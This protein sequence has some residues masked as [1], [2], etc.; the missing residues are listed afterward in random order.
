MQDRN[1]N[2]REN[3]FTK[4]TRMHIGTASPKTSRRQIPQITILD[5]ANK[6]LKCSQ[7]EKTFTQDCSLKRHFQSAHTGTRHNCHK[8]SKSF[9]RT[10][11]LNNH[12]SNVHFIKRDEQKKSRVS[13]NFKNNQF[14]T[15]NSKD[16]SMRIIQLDGA[17][18]SPS[19]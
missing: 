6:T 18:S 5:H 14:S 3:D 1:D 2:F 16:E 10:Y 13:S 12:L 11:L 7:C 4:K 17:C 8:C 15:T 19:K 9:T